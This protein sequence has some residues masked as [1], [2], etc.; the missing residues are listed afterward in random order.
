MAASYLKDPDAIYRAS[1]AAIRAAAPIDSLP[2][3]IQPLA[4]RLIHTS[5]MPDILD[6]LV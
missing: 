4:L 1:F 5:G 2:A 6:D 3:E